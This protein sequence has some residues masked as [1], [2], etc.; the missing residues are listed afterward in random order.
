MQR[1]SD[2]PTTAPE[3][4]DGLTESA[5]RAEAWAGEPFLRE[6]EDPARVLAPQTARR[7]AFDAALK[8][9]EEGRRS[10]SS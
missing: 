6:G 5:L 9:I 10:P 7:I 1:T 2:H 4:A 8:E 3:T